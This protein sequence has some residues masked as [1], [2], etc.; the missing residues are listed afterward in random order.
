LDLN[1]L[2]NANVQQNLQYQGSPAA[3]AIDRVEAFAAETVTDGDAAAQ[4]DES[5][6]ASHAINV[7]LTIPLPFVRFYLTVVG[8]RER[9]NPDRRVDERRKNPIA[10]TWN[11][12][13]LGLLGTTTGL[14]LFTVIQF[15]ARLVLEKAGVV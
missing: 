15:L 11:I 7:R 14:A 13:F 4:K 3:E 12:V 6:R 1:G 8:G 10:T 5:W 9:R 2:W